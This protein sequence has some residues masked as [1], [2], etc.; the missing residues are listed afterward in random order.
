MHVSS[1]STN[2]NKHTCREMPRINLNKDMLIDIRTNL[3]VEHQIIGAFLGVT[4]GNVFYGTGG[5]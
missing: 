5:V 3:G 2:T 1:S 4:I